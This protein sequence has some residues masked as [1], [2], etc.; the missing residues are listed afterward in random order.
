MGEGAELQKVCLCSLLSSPFHLDPTDRS[1]VGSGP[2]WA[3]GQVRENG[4]PSQVLPST[5]E[6]AAPPVLGLV[7]GSGSQ[8][9][10]TIPQ[11]VGPRILLVPCWAQEVGV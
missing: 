5:R 11:E 1:T 9:K 4:L 2:G 10:R 6:M 8:G 3:R 7:R